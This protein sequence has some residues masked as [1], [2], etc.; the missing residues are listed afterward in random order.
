MVIFLMQ[1]EILE[2]SVANIKQLSAQQHADS[3]SVDS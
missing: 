3:N 1:R 2:F